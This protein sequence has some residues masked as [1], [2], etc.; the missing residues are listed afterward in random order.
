MTSTNPEQTPTTSTY[1][2]AYSYSNSKPTTTATA[3]ADSKSNPSLDFINYLISC[4]NLAQTKG[5]YTLQQAAEIHIKIEQFK[6]YLQ[7][8]NQ[9]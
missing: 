5:S 1:T 6:K 3:T 7:T 9:I 2:S 8:Q 4:V